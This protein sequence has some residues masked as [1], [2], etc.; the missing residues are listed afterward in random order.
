[1]TI[2]GL[3]VFMLMV[4]GSLAVVSNL[5]G[6]TASSSVDVNRASALS[7]QATKFSAQTWADLATQ[8][9]KRT[10]KHTE[11][12]VGEAGSDTDDTANYDA[13]NPFPYYS[14]VSTV[15]NTAV[16]VSTP[17]GATNSDGSY[18]IELLA[19][20]LGSTMADCT[21]FPT[22]ERPAV[23]NKCIYVNSIR[24]PRFTDA[25]A[26]PAWKG[27]GT[28]LTNQVTGTYKVTGAQTL[29]IATVN[30]CS[31][32]V[33]Q[34]QVSFLWKP[35]DDGS[36][37]APSLV[38]H[39]LSKPINGSD[40]AEFF[41]PTTT[42][43]NGSGITVSG[44]F[45]KGT[46]SV[47]GATDKLQVKFAGTGSGTLSAL[48]LTPTAQ[49]GKADSTKVPSP[50]QDFR[51]QVNS[52]GRYS[53][54]WNAGTSD[55]AYPAK[56]YQV[57][58]TCS[59]AGTTVPAQPNTN[60]NYTG[61]SFNFVRESGESI[62]DYIDRCPVY[63]VTAIGDNGSAKQ[64]QF[65]LSSLDTEYISMGA[66]YTA[67]TRKVTVSIPEF[68]DYLQNRISDLSVY[69]CYQSATHAG[70]GCAVAPIKDMT[71]AT[72]AG[73]ISYKTASSFSFTAPALK[74]IKGGKL[75]VQG[76]TTNTR[77]ATKS[78]TNTVSVTV[79]N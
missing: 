16:Y 69:Y 52:S 77:N 63:R 1:M 35:A 4:V 30:T 73:T 48:L 15:D 10:V 64:V 51:V 6:N 70:E 31:M 55:T 7:I 47:C 19:P 22:F 50:A 46:S 37:L 56:S 67:S 53:L 40:L 20:K 23:S 65:A 45:N 58:S 79:T 60:N 25:A 42:S 41:T 26:V 75:I 3:S 2:L 54:A 21:R 32:V 72:K 61:G 62:E 24:A 8:A 78:G 71:N 14:R 11:L 38:Q 43:V 59:T 34:V 12:R 28:T 27:L 68:P 5:T 66:S 33:P 57:A 18:V 13:P 44:Y 9:K 39:K 17:D 49:G 74:D 36:K 76:I 29:D